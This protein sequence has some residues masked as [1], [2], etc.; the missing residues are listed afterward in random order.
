MFCYKKLIQFCHSYNTKRT[1]AIRMEANEH[2][3][4]GGE[5]PKGVGKQSEQEAQPL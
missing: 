2:D 5:A 1:V 3:G 4:E